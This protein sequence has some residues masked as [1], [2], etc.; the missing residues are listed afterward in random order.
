[1]PLL[2]SAA[3]ILVAIVAFVLVWKIFKKLLAAI[4]LGAILLLVL[5][6]FGF[7]L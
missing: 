2:N 6:Y 4:V 1:M 7:L 5:W 3:S